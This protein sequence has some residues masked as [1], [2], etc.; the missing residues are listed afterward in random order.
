MNTQGFPACWST[1]SLGDTTAT[2]PMDLAALQA[3]LAACKGMHSRLF[4]LHGAA[5]AISGFVAAR[6][7]T[8]ALTV[9]AIVVVVRLM[10]LQ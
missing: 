7:V 10:V 2:L 9:V 1:A 3:H 8:S 5:E 4:G 6:F